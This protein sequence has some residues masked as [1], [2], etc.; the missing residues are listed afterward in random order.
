MTEPERDPTAPPTRA[1]LDLGSTIVGADSGARKAR[2]FPMVRLVLI[3][4]LVSGCGFLGSDSFSGT[5]TGDGIAPW[6]SLGPAQVCLG[7]QYLGPPDAPPGG[8]CFDQN[9]MEARCVADDDCRSRET[10][11]CGRC[12]VAYCASASDCGDDRV[13]TF[14]EHRCDLSCLTG[15]DCP[16]GAE[17]RNAVCRGRC[18]DASD[19]QTGEV[20]NSMNVCVSA[21]CE[22]DDGCLA[23]ESCRVQRVPRQVLE[24]SAAIDPEDT[25]GRPVVLWLE[26]ADQLQRDE[27]A[28]WRAVSPDGVHFDMN[29]ATPVLTD[30]TT[31][32][33]PSVIRIVDGWAMYYEVSAG[34]E[35]RV[36]TSPDGITWSA[37]TRAITGGL[38]AAAARAPSAVALPDGSVAVY[39][40][41]GDGAAIALAT[42]NVGGALTERGNVLVPS[43]VTIPDAGDGTPFWLAVERVASPYA[44]LS[45]GV[46]GPSLRLY[47]SAYGAES[48]D[49]FQFGEIVA[50]PP[51]FSVGYAS[52]EV[53]DPAALQPW[54][55]GPIVDRVT[56][57]LDHHDELTPSVLQLPD[58]TG[59]LLYYV[60]ADPDDTA[61]GPD[62]PYVIGRLGV[63][64][65]GSYSSI[66]AP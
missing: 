29:P 17:C 16:D 33:A 39:Y 45:D 54:P 10:C 52:A 9:V 30:G 61:T 50:L 34:A 64:G 23:S 24:P 31:A 65:N 8:L 32:R 11:V 25:S 2:S 19:C 57:F 53:D 6:T 40:Q 4:V 47:Y 1:K 12:T 38:G 27:T 55:Y 41:V 36:V 42:G 63:L 15:A 3:A 62:G 26:I 21:D 5:R 14:A 28:I 22:D 46:A 58:R 60:D 7:N 48:G 13:C 35:I 44:V 66:T 51:N 49:S 56:A 20:C 37:P 59:Y 43:D 18:I